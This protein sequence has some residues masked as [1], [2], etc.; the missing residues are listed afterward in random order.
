MKNK[1]ITMTVHFQPRMPGPL[2]SDER[3]QL[4]DFFMAVMDLRPQ[5]DV[6]QRDIYGTYK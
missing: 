1:K 5:E 2:L 3:K 6:K 4:T